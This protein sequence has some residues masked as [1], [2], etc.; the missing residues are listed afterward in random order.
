MD[1]HF[2]CNCGG[3]AWVSR[4]DRMTLI[5]CAQCG[6]TISAET[7]SLAKSEWRQRQAANSPKKPAVWPTQRR[8]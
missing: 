8:R 5:E 1:R 3:T 6:T 4:E 7:L 2:V